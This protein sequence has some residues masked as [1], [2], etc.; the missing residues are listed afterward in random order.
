MNES[1]I[2]KRILAL[3]EKHVIKKFSVEVDSTLLGYRTRSIL[4]VDVEPSKFLQVGG[5]LSRTT[6]VRSVS[7]TLGEHAF[8]IEVWAEDQDSLSKIVSNK[9][10]KIDGVT[11]ISPLIVVEK[12]K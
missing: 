4:G 10:S 12:L 3:R 8:I 11:R 6:E 7:I 1:T 2:R 9:S 5:Q